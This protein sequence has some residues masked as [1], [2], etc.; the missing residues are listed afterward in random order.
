[1]TKFILDAM[2]YQIFIFN[3]DKF[4]LENL[5]TGELAGGGTL[6]SDSLLFTGKLEK[7]SDG[8][9]NIVMERKDFSE[10]FNNEF[11]KI[12]ES[13][14]NESGSTE[15]KSK[16]YNSLKINIGLSEKNLKNSQL[17]M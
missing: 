14:Y 2:Y 5:N 10:V 6:I 9:Y 7:N 16:I 13:N 4:I 12:L 17:K 3:R 11:G 8:K 15:E 1:M